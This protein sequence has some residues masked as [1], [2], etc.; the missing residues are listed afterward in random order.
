MRVFYF[1]KQRYNNSLG[2][3][4]CFFRLIT[5][6]ILEAT[7]TRAYS[8][9]HH[10]ATFK[11]KLCYDAVREAGQFDRD[12]LRGRTTRG[13]L[14]RANRKDANGPLRHINLKARES[15]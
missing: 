12:A 6:I 15:P 14:G 10:D 5:E 2:S 11:G 9:I 4:W 3:F 1:H 7:E 13:S 8:H